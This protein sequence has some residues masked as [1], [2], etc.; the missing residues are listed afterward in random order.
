MR[1]ALWILMVVVVVVVVGCV[2]VCVCVCARV[3]YVLQVRVYM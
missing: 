1:T 3:C 2:C